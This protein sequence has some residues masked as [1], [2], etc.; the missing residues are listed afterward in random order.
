[1]NLTIDLSE[2][3]AAALEARARAARMPAERYLAEI[4]T[5]ALERQ[6]RQDVQNLEK[7]LDYMASQV[8]PDTTV[9]EMEAALQE[10]LTHVRPHRDWRP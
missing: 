7:H 9:D 5:R 8:V 6:H 10:A 2:H 4:V 1:M 3:D